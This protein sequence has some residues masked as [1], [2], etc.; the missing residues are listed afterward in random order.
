MFKQIIGK[1][2]RVVQVEDGENGI[3]YLGLGEDVQENTELCSK[4][5]VEAKLPAAEERI[6]NLSKLKSELVA[7]L[8]KAVTAEDVSFVREFLKAPV[9]DGE[10][11][12]A[13]TALQLACLNGS[14]EIVE[15]LL[16]NGADIEKED[17][18][19]RQAIHF[20]VKG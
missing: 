20:A 5:I 17:A 9:N 7:L 11:P 6:E 18:K 1:T 13:V 16:Q 4:W 3:V 19:G 2:G 15:L 8:M 10:G 12:K 14:I